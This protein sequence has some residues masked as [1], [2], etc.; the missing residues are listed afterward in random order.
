MGLPH[1]LFRLRPP[2]AAAAGGENDWFQMDSPTLRPLRFRLSAGDFE[3]RVMEHL[4][5]IPFALW[6]NQFNLFDSHDIAR[7]HN[8]PDVNPEEW[9]GAVCLQYAMI[10]APSIYYGDEAAAEGWIHNIEGCRFPMPWGKDFRETEAWQLNHTLAHL[11]QTSR[12]LGEGGFK[13]LYAADGVV[14]VARF[15]KEEAYVA[16]MSTAKEEQR[17]VLP[18]GAIGATGFAADVLGRELRWKRVDENHAELTLEP[19]GAYFA[20]CEMKQ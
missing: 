8:N 4:A 15:V 7:L 10:G 9:R 6:E 12:A 1:E 17:V 5:K 2:G 3:R 14:A 19:H 11:K 20:A 18:L 16:V 13:F